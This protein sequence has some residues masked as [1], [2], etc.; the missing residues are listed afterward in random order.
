M[1]SSSTTS[2]RFLSARFFAPL[3]IALVLALARPGAADEPPFGAPV[4]GTNRLDGQAVSNVLRRFTVPRGFQVDLW[5]AEPDVQNPVSIC[6]DEQGRLYVVESHRRRTSVFDI[7]SHKDWL[8]TDF[9]LRTVED[10]ANFYQWAAFP[11]D[12]SAKPRAHP[13]P[14]NGLADFNGD[15]VIDWRDLEVE[16]ERI[17]ILEDTDGSGRASRVTTF[18]EGFKTLVSGVAAGILVRR[19]DVFFTCI[20]DLWKLHVPDGGG[21]ADRRVKL[22]ERLRG[23]YRLRRP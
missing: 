12:P 6:F 14:K 20:P 10:R 11:A 5:A 23:A 9:S 18:A 16:S 15:G 8:E 21:P 1:P 19:G 3:L 22:L 2:T 7:R 17:R 13:A 4:I